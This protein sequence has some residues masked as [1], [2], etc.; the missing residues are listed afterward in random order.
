[1][2]KRILMP[3]WT[4]AST[5]VYTLVL[6]FPTIITAILSRTGRLPF[7][8]G[9]LW[10]WL[11]L[12]SNRVKVQVIGSEK[13]K[14]WRS[15]VFISNHASNLD[16]L[17]VAQGIRNTLRFVGKRSLFKIPFFGWAVSLAR[18]IPIDRSDGPA[19]VTRINRVV[20][21]LREGISVYFFAEGTRSGDGTLQKFKKGGVM[22]A[23]RSRL[24]IVPITIVNSNR[25]LPKGSLLVSPGTLKVIIGDP[26][27]TEGM[28]DSA[29]D[30]LLKKV[31]GTI[32]RNLRKFSSTLRE[33]PA[34]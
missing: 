19:A 21:E 18:M 32:A 17:A 27:E 4:L 5:T 20:R 6:A 23:L 12:K 13:I 24:P 22:F 14:N 26:I 25:L 29:R 2:L 11:I 10:V 31:R 9:K 30:L 1:M 7:S 3:A 28:K 33:S 34:H 8:I 16:P 15:Y